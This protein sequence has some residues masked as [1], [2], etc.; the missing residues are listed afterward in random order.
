[1]RFARELQPFALR[2]HSRTALTLIGALMGAVL[3]TKLNVGGYVL[4]AV[5]YAT[6]MWVPR[7]SLRRTL[8]AGAT[9]AHICSSDRPS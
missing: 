8:R 7:L 5:G 3:L 9:A 6:V 1:M 4:I 2:A